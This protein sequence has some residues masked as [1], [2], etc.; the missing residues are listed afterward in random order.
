MGDRFDITAFHDVVLRSGTVTIGG[1]PTEDFPLVAT[2][3]RALSCE[4]KGKGSTTL[5][6]DT[7]VAGAE[8]RLDAPDGK[9]VAKGSSGTVETGNWITDGREVFLRRESQAW[10]GVEDMDPGPLSDVIEYDGEIH[11]AAN[12]F[13]ALKEGYYGKF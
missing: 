6:W 12:L 2:P 3:A 5:T 10:L 13:D 8:L 1:T 4:G 7:D 9:I 11:T